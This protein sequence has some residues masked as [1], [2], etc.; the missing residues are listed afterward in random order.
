[1]PPQLQEYIDSI[2]TLPLADAI[3][4]I[5]SLTPSL[6]TTVTRNG[7]SQIH[8]PA[9]LGPANLDDLGRHFL[10]SAVRCQNEHASFQL[11]LLHHSLDD[12]FSSLYGKAFTIFR[13]GY[14]NGSI[15]PEPSDQE[16]C[17]CCDGEP[18]AVIGCG[19]HEGRALLF[20]E[21]EYRRIWGDVEPCGKVYGRE[22]WLWATRKQVEEAMGRDGVSSRL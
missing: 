20:E 7:K 6:T 12:M 19:F 8:H 2:P 21:E 17:P 14:D 5:H 22:V 11:R 15:V 4:A 18:A 1:M 3:Q 10:D 13:E 9:Y 16:G